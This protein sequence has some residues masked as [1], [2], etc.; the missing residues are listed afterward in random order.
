MILKM[1]PVVNDKD[2]RPPITP[3]AIDQEIEVVIGP[4]AHGGH[5]IAHALGNT[6]FVRGGITGERVII[7]IS[8]KRKRIY[9]AVVS[10][11]L[12]ASPDRVSPICS[13]S[14]KCGGC[15]FQY[16]AP[17]VQRQLKLQVLQESLVRFS[18]LDQ[19]QIQAILPTEIVLLGANAGEASRSRARFMWDGQ[20]NMRGYMNAE[21]IPTPHCTVISE[22]MRSTMAEVAKALPVVESGTAVEYSFVE[23]D[24]GVSVEAM[25]RPVMGPPKVVHSY[26]G[27]T[28]RTP[29][30][31]FWQSNPELIGSVMGF[32]DSHL[33][34]ESGQRWWDLYSG[35]GVFAGYLCQ[36]VGITGSVF[37]V[38]GDRQGSQSAKRA[39]HDCQNISVV[40][41]DVQD[42]LN[43]IENTQWID[44]VLLDPPRVGAGQLVCER[45][46]ELSPGLI[47]YLACDPVALSRDIE[48]L[49]SH[50]RLTKLVAYDAFPM[51]HHF[52]TVAL[53]ERRSNLS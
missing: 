28:Y 14:G 26:N 49:S 37:S 5:F 22:P 27:F 30:S 3:L 23:G 39:F 50:Y 24:S 7:R 35:A 34:V 29:V 40:N 42:F 41:A 45:I 6:I 20:W 43:T 31:S 33:A 4:I 13:S 9:N 17:D 19:E 48:L 38:E 44:G 53:L 52:E 32:L 11:V 15:D 2:T 10:T 25:G 47:A 18:G 51:T 36:R 46:V 21:L 16:I 12:D 8:A 1:S